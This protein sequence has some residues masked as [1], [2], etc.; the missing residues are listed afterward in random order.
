VARLQGSRAAC[1][2]KRIKRVRLGR[3]RRRVRIQYTHKRHH[4]RSTK[5]YINVFILCY[6]IYYIIYIVYTV[7][8][9]Y[10]C[11]CVKETDRA[12]KRTDGN[13][14]AAAS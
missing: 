1:I 4:R 11:V 5:L 10:Q 13:N 14:A 7:Y 2:Y 8:T 9:I 6:Y 3:R 12:E